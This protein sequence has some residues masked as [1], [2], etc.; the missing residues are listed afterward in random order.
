MQSLGRASQLPTYYIM[1]RSRLAGLFLLSTALTSGLLAQITWDFT[2]ATTPSSELPAGLISA[3]IAQFNTTT[4]GVNSTSASSGYTG[5]TGG[6]NMAFSAKNGALDTGSSTY[7]EVTLTP[8]SGHGLNLSAI[9]FGSRST[10]T[11]PTTLT[12]FLSTNLTGSIGSATASA[13]S[14][15]VLHSFSD[16]SITSAQDTPLIFRIYGTGGTTSPTA[17]WRIDDLSLSV[18]AV[19]EPSAFAVLGGLAT[20]GFAATR[21]RRRLAA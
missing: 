9:T 21:R 17:N 2:S 12:L 13:D 18:S 6:N 3:S 11:G 19:P 16:L 15:W 10:S 20:L 5:A 7:F 14:N 4:T 8:G 1:N